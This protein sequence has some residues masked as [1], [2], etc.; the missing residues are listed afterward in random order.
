MADKIA[1]LLSLKNPIEAAMM[2]PERMGMIVCIDI[3]GGTTRLAFAGDNKKI[4]RTTKFETALLFDSQLQR[5]IDEIKR[6]NNNPKT[7]VIGAAGLVDREQG[8]LI[9]WGQRKSWQGQSFKNRLG[10]EFPQTKL[11]VE[12]DANLAALGEAWYGAGRNQSVVAYLTLSSGIGGG[13]VIDKKII[14]HRFGLEPGH[15]IINSLERKSWSCG[16]KGC[17]EAY[18]SGTAFDKIF[19][20]KPEYCSDQRL[21]KAYAKLLAPGVANTL[22]FWSPDVL[23]FG[24]GVSRKFKNFILPLREALRELLPDF[25][26][27]PLVAA[28][29]PEPGLSGGLV[30][31]KTGGTSD[32][33]D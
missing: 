23:I 28:Q 2:A 13:L 11:F 32:V 16:Q 21:W 31:C 33:S 29:L 17:F 1:I 3:G 30:Y 5:I 12:N 25:E 14:P 27:P 15:Q 18:G 20:V 10:P 22:V 7:I 26:I 4:S 8:R 24:G 9:S 6:S 19:G